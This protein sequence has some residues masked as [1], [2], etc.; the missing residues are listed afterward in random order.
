MDE[1]MESPDNIAICKVIL[2]DLPN[3]T[4]APRLLTHVNPCMFGNLP[5]KPTNDK[6]CFKHV[7][8]RYFLHV[9]KFL[10]AKKHHP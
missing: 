2:V 3:A 8:V 6:I 10:A 1:S 4:T 9:Q 7:Q 5:Q